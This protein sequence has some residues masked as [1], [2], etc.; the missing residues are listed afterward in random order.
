MRSDAKFEE[1]L[2]ACLEAVDKDGAA[3]RL[4]AVYPEYAAELA[5]LLENHRRVEGWAAPLREAAAGETVTHPGAGADVAEAPATVGEYEIL[6]EVGRGGM[7]V[8]YQARQRGLNRLVALKMIRGG[9]PEDERRFRHEAEAAAR[10]DHPNIVPIYEVGEHD[11]RPFFSMKFIDGTDLGRAAA[12]GPATPRAIARLMADVA[13]AVHHAHQ[14]GI[15]HR[16]LKPSNILLDKDGRPHVADFGLAK[17]VEGDSA[18]TLSGS[19]TGT[20]SYMAPEQAAAAPALTTAVDVYGLGAILYELLTGRPPFRAG[21][22]LDTILQ[23]RTQEPPRPRSLN[24]RADRDLETI[25]LKCL[26]RDPARR[27]GSAEALA[28][29]LERWLAGEPTLARP[30]SAWEQLAKWAK[31][32]PGVAA[33]LGVA[34][35]LLVAVLG[36]LAWGWQQSADKAN[37]QAAARAA[38]EEK[39]EAEKRRAEE[40]ARGERLVQAHLALE[41]GTNRLDRGEIAAGMLWLARGL[42]V[43][44]DD[45]AD[46]RRSLRTLLGGW[47]RDVPSLKA[48]DRHDQRVNTIAFSPDGKKVLTASDDKTARLWDADTGKPL[49]EPLRHAGGVVWAAFAP[50]GASVLTASHDDGVHLWR[51]DAATCKR[52]GKIISF[53]A[54]LFIVLS[55]DGKT[56]AVG[57]PL[58][59]GETE[60]QLWD[61]AAAKMLGRMG[62]SK[63]RSFEGAFSPDGTKFVFRKHGPGE[64]DELFDVAKGKLIGEQVMPKKE[65]GTRVAFSPDWKVVVT[66]NSSGKA[67]LWDATTGKALGEPIT[68]GSGPIWTAAFRPNGKEFLTARQDATGPKELT[69][70]QD[71]TVRR[72]DATT[73][74]PVGEPMR[75]GPTYRAAYSP[76]GKIILTV[77]DDLRFWDAASG[78]LLGM[79]L[80]HGAAVHTF[81][82]TPDGRGLWAG[83]GDDSARLWQ[84]PR[85]KDLLHE[86]A[87]HRQ[88]APVVAYSP[89]GKTVLTAG[90]DGTAR[91]WDAATG[92]LKGEVLDHGEG[93]VFAA[94]FS[95]DGNWVL[96]AFEP[97]NRKPPAETRLWDART[98]KPLGEP[99]KHDK[100]IWA[101]AFAPDGKSFLTGGEQPRLWDP[102]TGRPLC[103]PLQHDGIASA[104]AFSRDG[105]M[106]LTSSRWDVMTRNN[107]VV[108]LWETATGKPVGQPLRH[109]HSVIAANFSADG[110]TVLTVTG[111]LGCDAVLWDVATT[112]PLGRALRCWDGPSSAALSPDGKTVATLQVENG[113]RLWEAATGRPIG[114][115]LHQQARGKG[116]GKVV[117]SPDGRMILTDAGFEAQ[118]WDV[119]SQK[120]IGRPIQLEKGWDPRFCNVAFSPD[121]GTLLTSGFDKVPRLWRVPAPLEGEPERIRLWI[122][123]TAGLE[124]DAG[125]AV[126]ELGTKAWRE[127]WERLQKLGGP[128]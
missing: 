106:F 123:L 36:V 11:G 45:A 76:D 56:V 104:V 92:R 102:E 63:G 120:P 12:R 66:A 37:A 110:R 87:G 114:E 16:D 97:R 33:L 27:Y 67:Q 81:A 79:P 28:D 84:L 99:L 47:T 107:W 109:D 90:S 103:D 39:A 98:G 26:E 64:Q 105:K 55:P 6:A 60:A 13:R 50:D 19:V 61:L 59:G 35:A 41:K 77:G 57:E 46:L 51:W 111:G 74:A 42:E 95:P 115:S 22:P 70:G 15:L 69:S 8:V 93:N 125:G 62:R 82:F 89:D 54:A 24:P 118:L 20:P 5:E 25:C 53:P 91:L 116:A 31:R 34:A 86:L 101:V 32:R 122:E 43:A 49:G 48:V 126:V 17:R 78:Q 2:V 1:A 38:A 119:S 72:W 112:K 68:H 117:F 14:R 44:P 80:Q 52:L 71:W 3:E 94:T 4:L 88:V 29:D 85:Q 121:G 83:G 58:P 100:P 18:T 108:M 124:L 30:A 65:G 127:R 73:G 75:T 128:P 10:L 96:T 40:A 113:V 9:G 23:A 7:G 21:T